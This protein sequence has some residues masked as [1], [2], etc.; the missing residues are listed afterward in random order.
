MA[1]ISLVANAGNQVVKD[2][3]DKKIRIEPVMKRLYRLCQILSQK[4]ATTIVICSK[5]NVI[6]QI[7]WAI[8]DPSIRAEPVMEHPDHIIFLEIISTLIHSAFTTC[9][10]VDSVL[11]CITMIIH[12]AAVK[13]AIIRGQD[14][15]KTVNYVLKMVKLALITVVVLFCRNINHSKSSLYSS[16]NSS[17]VTKISKTD[18]KR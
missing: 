17:I 10:V 18:E 13:I 12:L 2:I 5:A 11:H 7:V 6:D 14:G 9:L 8:E 15:R 4:S 16:T 1:A 3:G